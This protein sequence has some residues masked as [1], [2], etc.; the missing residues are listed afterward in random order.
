MEAAGDGDGHVPEGE[1]GESPPEGTVEGGI[2]GGIAACVRWAWLS[3][4]LWWAV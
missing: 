4:T 3:T 2:Q 1:P